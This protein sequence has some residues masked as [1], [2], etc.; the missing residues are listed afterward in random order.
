MLYNV[1]QRGQAL[2][3]QAIVGNGAAAQTRAHAFLS[4]Q[5][6][7]EALSSLNNATQR[8]PSVCPDPQASPGMRNHRATKY[9]RSRNLSTK[10]E[11][12]A[13]GDWPSGSFG[14]QVSRVSGESQERV[15]VHER[16]ENGGIDFGIRHIHLAWRDKIQNPGQHSSLIQ[17]SSGNRH[18]LPPD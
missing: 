11:S 14:T 9:G 3:V 2:T 1:Q 8:R 16:Y 15:R 7:R 17:G 6:D 12:E 13:I 10:G 4:S 18:G 5:P